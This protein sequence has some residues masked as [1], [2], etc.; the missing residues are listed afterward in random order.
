M[1]LTYRIALNFLA[2][3]HLAS[4]RHTLYHG[5]HNGQKA[6]HIGQCWTD[7][8]SAAE[9][10]SQGSGTITRKSV[11]LSGLEIKEVAPYNRDDNYAVGDSQ[12]D[13]RRLQ[14]EGVD[15]ITFEDEDM[16]GHRHTT[17][18]IVSEKGLEAFK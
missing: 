9:E 15:L 14:A 10:Y 4:N 13:I 1:D 6:P 16:R 12:S 2:S 11:D 5:S 18:R 7:T 3:V 17:W 8:E